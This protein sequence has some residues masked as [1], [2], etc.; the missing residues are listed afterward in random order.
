[1][2]ETAAEAGDVSMAHE[3]DRNLG[4]WSV[5][6]H[7]FNKRKETKSCHLGGLGQYVESSVYKCGDESI[8]AGVEVNPAA[9]LWHW[10]NTECIWSL[11]QIE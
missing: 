7:L 2:G 1:M 5:L 11:C 10:E 8:Q 3:L 9:D 4:V 6:L